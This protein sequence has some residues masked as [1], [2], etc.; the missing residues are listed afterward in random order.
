MSPVAPL[1]GQLSSVQGLVGLAPSSLLDYRLFVLQFCL[2]LE[3]SG[4]SGFSDGS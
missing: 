1:V 4:V 2:F 3:F